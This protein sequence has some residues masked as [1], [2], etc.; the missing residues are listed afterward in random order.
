[1]QLN[2]IE[3]VYTTKDAP[4]L[5][6]FHNNH[7][8]VRGIMG[9]FGSGKSTACV[10][11]ILTRAMEQV[12]SPNGKRLS[13]WAIVRNSYPEL[14][15]TT[16]K[17]WGDW[18][19][20]EYGH[21]TLGSPIKHHIVT[22]DLDL[23]VLFLALDRA[24]D[25]KKLLSLELS[26]AWLNEAREIPKAILDAMTGRVGR[27]PS[28]I[29]GGCTWSGVIMD[30][31]PPDD[32]SWWYHLAEEDTPEGFSFFQQPSGDSDEAENLPNL[33]KGYYERI[34]AGKD[35]DWVKVYVRGQ[36]GFL[37]EGRPVFQSF[38]DRAHV[39]PEII[40]PNKEAPLLIGVDFG[41]T[42]AA[43]IGQLSVDG[44]WALVD[45]YCTEDMGITRFAENFNKYL[46]AN[47]GGYQFAGGYGDPAGKQK[48]Y[49]EE[50]AFQILNEY[51]PL[52][53]MDPSVIWRE[54]PSNDPLLRFEAVNAALDRMIDGS[55]GVL[56]SPNCKTIRKG[57][58][59]GY[60]YKYLK[61]GDGTQTQEIPN[62]NR[63]SHVMDA[64]QYLLLGGGEHEAVLRKVNRKRDLLTSRKP[65]VAKDLEYDLFN[66]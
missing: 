19:P 57:F 5:Q 63:Y 15:T 9:P 39:S 40:V 53:P 11:E 29:M 16:L 47:W 34:S 37:V 38:R 36:Y 18:C 10:M 22:P 20:P 4:T 12:P 66:L 35:P 65:V 23:E 45:E 43:A 59:G 46:R 49:R 33:P 50:T 8:F 54:A 56:V 61:S 6:R 58:N 2:P 24:E 41:L 32:H 64:V 7:D 27:Y 3:R 28:R 1:L 52:D 17:T 62:K 42:P 14:R 30:T 55:A 31:N 44:R 51:C 13:R 26:G 60:H 48:G 21:L 25:Q